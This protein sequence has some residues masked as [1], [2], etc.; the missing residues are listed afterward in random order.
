MVRYGAE[1]KLKVL[2]TLSVL[3]LAALVLGS[4]FQIKAFW[5]LAAVLL[6]LYLVW[7]GLAK[8]VS[9]IW[10]SFSNHL[11][12]LMTRILLSLCFYGVLTP[13]ALLYRF[14]NPDALGLKKGKKSYY[15]ERSERFNPEFFKRMW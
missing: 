2:E 10:L 13:M 7:F 4:I 5:I 14:F 15:H 1:I 6:T 9:D 3:A 11:G 12:N 8:R